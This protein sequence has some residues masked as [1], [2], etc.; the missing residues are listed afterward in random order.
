MN[1]V[2]SAE[3]LDELDVVVLVAVAGKHDQVSLAPG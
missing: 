1:A 2:L 3:G